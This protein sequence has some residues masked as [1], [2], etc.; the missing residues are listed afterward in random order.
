MVFNIKGTSSLRDATS[1]DIDLICKTMINI[2]KNKNIYN[3]QGVENTLPKSNTPFNS[4]T[5]KHVEYTIS[6]SMGVLLIYTK[7]SFTFNQLS[8]LMISKFLE[9]GKDSDVDLP[10]T[11]NSCKSTYHTLV[12]IPTSQLVSNTTSNCIDKSYR[13]LTASAYDIK[14]FCEAGSRFVWYVN[15]INNNPYLHIPELSEYNPSNEYL[16]RSVST[17][18]YDGIDLFSIDTGNKQLNYPALSQYKLFNDNRV[19]ASNILISEVFGLDYEILTH[20]IKSYVDTTMKVTAS[21]RNIVESK[22]CELVDYNTLEI[23]RVDKN[24]SWHSQIN[25]PFNY[26]VQ[27]ELEMNCNETGKPSFPN[28]VCF[29]THIPLYQ[30]VY[31]L[32]IAKLLNP[33][34]LFP[35]TA[36]IKHIMISP[37]VYHSIINGFI[38][39]EYFKLMCKYIIMEVSISDYPKTELDIITEIPDDKIHPIKKDILQC[40][41]QNGCSMVSSPNCH[42]KL[43]TI[44]LEKKIIYLGYANFVDSIIAENIHTNTILFNYKIF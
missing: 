35:R 24:K 20:Y 25:N 41:S 26:K 19:V 8:N 37:L 31:I 42:K 14:R 6:A 13:K 15:I 44:N 38:F 12:T 28:N 2:E 43:Y 1:L 40:I 16:M 32:K 11:N 34:D 18:I 23:C 22:F 33:D 3:L 39:T 5:H 4:Y 21:Y 10:Y 29:I 30:N 27:E 36:D 7:E 9:L 17:I